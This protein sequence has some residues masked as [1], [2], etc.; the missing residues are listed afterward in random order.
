MPPQRSK[1]RRTATLTGSF[2]DKSGAI[3]DTSVA[4]PAATSVRDADMAEAASSRGRSGG[5]G[6]DDSDDECCLSGYGEMSSDTMFM[7]PPSPTQTIQYRYPAYRTKLAKMNKKRRA[8]A[9]GT[10]K[11]KSSAYH[12]GKSDYASLLGPS[13]EGLTGLSPK[14]EFQ[15]LLNKYRDSAEGWRDTDAHTPPRKTYSD[16][17][18]SP[19]GTSTGTALRREGS[20]L[21][22]NA[23]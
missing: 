13:F 10:S 7:L 2:Y 22:R 8:A 18:W 19:A 14:R 20:R 11:T 3:A 23:F 5:R 4:S 1:L 17:A 16:K 21:G 12:N 15:A 6:G 9:G